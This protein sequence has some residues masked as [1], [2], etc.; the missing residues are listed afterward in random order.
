MQF[1]KVFRLAPLLAPMPAMLP[2]MHD[3]IIIAHVSILDKR[4]LPPTPSEEILV[5]C[6]VV[7]FWG[8]TKQPIIGP[9]FSPKIKKG[10]RTII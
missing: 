5:R 10:K 9:E 2:G 8:A 1:S 6:S 3:T 7:M 4:E